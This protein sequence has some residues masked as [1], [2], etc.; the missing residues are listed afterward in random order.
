MRVTIGT[1]L[2]F[3]CGL[4]VLCSPATAQITIDPAFRIAALIR[5]SD[6]PGWPDDSLGV[7]VVRGGMD[8]NE[9]GKKEFII[10]GDPY[11]GPDAPDDSLHPYLFWFENTGDD[12]YACLWWTALPGSNTSVIISY[13]DFIVSD[14]DKDGKQEIVVVVPRGRIDPL[15]EFIFFYEFDNGAFPD[16]PTFVSDGA[17]SPGLRYEPARVLVNDVDG[18]GQD[19]MIIISRRDDFGGVQLGGRTMLVLNLVGGDI[20]TSSFSYLEMEFADSSSILKGGG[21]YDVGV[22]DY[23]R[24]GKKE[25]WVFTWDLFSLAIYEATAANTY[26]LQADINQARPDNDVGARHSMSFYDTDGDGKLEMYVAGITDISNP[27][28]IHC[29]GSTDD[30][31]TLSTSSVITLTPD[32]QEIDSWTYEGASIGD[33]DGDGKMDYII[34]G[35]GRNEIFRFKYL[36]GPVADPLSYEMSTIY[37]DEHPDHDGWILQFLWMGQDLDGDGKKEI[38]VTNRNPRV[39]TD[40]ER[41][42]ILEVTEGTGVEGEV[43]ELPV[44]FSLEQNYPNPFNP[45]TTIR[46]G[47][48]A[49]SYVALAVFN[50]LGQQVASLVQGER[51]AGYHEVMLDASGLS[52]GVYFYRLTA[53]DFMETRRLVVTK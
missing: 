20:S 37:K 51:E 48:P 22:V 9:N 40:D 38:V 19:E 7:T 44:S 45:S 42:I 10:L 14:M 13:S 29:I 46:Y 27:G 3:A 16:Q 24:D 39:D 50:A 4:L 15:S 35:G 28:N 25:I 41:V 34:A 17:L 6:V 1:V 49:R 11:Y 8:I 53:G 43:G 30:V 36:G 12:S 31:S 21:V 23:D 2:L 47:V 33:L 18:D 32:L 52:S 5:P 26:A